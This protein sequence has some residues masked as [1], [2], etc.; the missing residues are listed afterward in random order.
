MYIIKLKLYTLTIGWDTQVM[1]SAPQNSRTGTSQP[2]KAARAEVERALSF[3][4]QGNK[5]EALKALRKAL[6][7]DPGLAQ[8]KLATNLAHELTGLPI[9]EALE[10]L[11]DVHSSRAII[12]TAQRDLRRAPAMRRQRVLLAVFVVLSLVFIGL[13]VWSIGD[14]TL[15]RVFQPP[16]EPPQ[17]Y[18]LDGYDYYVAVP[19]GAI[20]EGGWPVV[21]AFHGY[22][23]DAGQLLPLSTTFNEAGAIM[24]APTFGTYEPN[25]GNGPIESASRILNEVASQY[26]LQARGAILFGF[27]QGG[28]FAYRFS[29][30]YSSQVAAVVAAGAPELDPVLPSRNIPYVFTWGELDELQN[31]V[32]P[33]VYVIQNNGF[34]ARIGIVPA[35]GHQ[36]S[37]YAIDQVLMF[38][39]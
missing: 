16:P 14:G 6:G 31:Y 20:P 1:N 12:D 11:L 13:L 9:P 27:S 21:V 25:P 2:S 35:V 3:H 32:L 18:T 36:V 5:G 22:G 39:K 10:T 4:F 17:K 8:E 24:V 30:Y 37:R 28:T 7:L 15:Q 19:K 23:G 29:V 26:P 34:N 38:L 33:S